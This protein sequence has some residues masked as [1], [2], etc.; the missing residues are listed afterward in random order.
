M[1]QETSLLTDQKSQKLFLGPV[2]EVFYHKI[3]QLLFL[4]KII[5]IISQ[6]SRGTVN[7]L[8]SIGRQ[9]K[10]LGVV[11]GLDMTLECT[12]AKLS[13]LLGKVKDSLSI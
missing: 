9:I 12:V 4:G 7:D 3:S 13:Y 8:Y 6:C 2:K 10:E 5:V 1:A 11:S